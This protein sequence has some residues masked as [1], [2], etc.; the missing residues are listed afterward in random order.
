MSQSGFLRRWAQ[1]K[2]HVAAESQSKPSD[3][4]LALQQA[5]PAS[6]VPPASRPQPASSAPA[7][8]LPAART[9]QPCVQPGSEQ[10]C[11]ESNIDA[12]PVG[13]SP[14]AQATPRSGQTLPALDTLT[15]ADD[16]SP[17]MQAG[18]DTGT[19]NAALK[20]LF[21]DPHFNVMDGLD[22]YIDDYS[23]P[24]PMPASMLRALRQ[25]RTLGL[26]D[27]EPAPSGQLDG[28]AVQPSPDQAAS[29]A[30]VVADN[31]LNNAIDASDMQDAGAERTC[32]SE[33]PDRL[34]A[35]GACSAIDHSTAEQ[36]VGGTPS[37]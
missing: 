9:G 34:E 10:A 8:A 24:D 28:A 6:L 2:A 16:F 3:Q 21:S 36:V 30:P 14:A 15:P 32:M 11:A 4:D 23:K 22:I 1:R 29:G 13:A 18:I 12:T 7:D 25:A 20:K 5:A 17:F 31:R 19:R 35:D 37:V 33:R 27:E 26:V